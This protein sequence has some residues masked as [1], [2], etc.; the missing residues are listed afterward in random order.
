MK[1]LITIIAGIIFCL[2][3]IIK[4]IDYSVI[5]KKVDIINLKRLIS[6]VDDH[7]VTKVKFYEKITYSK[8]IKTINKYPDF[9]DHKIFST[10]LESILHIAK[11]DKQFRAGMHSFQ[12]EFNNNKNEVIKKLKLKNKMMAARD[13]EYLKIHEKKINE[14]ENKMLLAYKYGGLELNKKYYNELKK[15][16]KPIN[17]IL[18]RKDQSIKL[19]NENEA[20]ERQIKDIEDGKGKLFGYIWHHSEKEGVIELVCKDIHEKNSHKGGNSEWGKGMR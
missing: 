15:L 12:K 10:K 6:N 1:K 17:F 16:T 14:I 3:I 13:N 7:T 19:L 20:L 11:D 9:G 8:G 2:I 5:L 18:V 4:K